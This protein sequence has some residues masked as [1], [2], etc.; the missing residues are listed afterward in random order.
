MDD[1]TIKEITTTKI[2]LEELQKDIVELRKDMKE[3]QKMAQTCEEFKNRVMKL[4][5]VITKISWIVGTALIGAVLRLIL[6]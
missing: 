1:N 2:L 4:E 6:K 5:G 3:Y